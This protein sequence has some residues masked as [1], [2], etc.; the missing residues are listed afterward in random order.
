MSRVRNV[1]PVFIVL[2][3]P[4]PIYLA[5]LDATAGLMVDDAWY[6]MLAKALANGEGYRLINSPIADIL[7]MYPPGF[8]ALLSLGFH[9]YP[10]FP[11]NLWV[12]KSLSI[13]AMLGVGLLSYTY[14]HRDRQLPRHLAACA[15]VAITTTPALVFLAT[16]TVMSECVFTLA[17]LGAV[18]AA[19]R[20][21]Q[22]SAEGAWRLVVVAALLAAAAM[23]IR[24]AGVA[25]IAAIGIFFLKDLQWKRAL[26][27]AGVLVISL[28][29]WLVYARAHHPTPEQQESHRGSIVY[30]YTDQ[31]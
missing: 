3:L 12:L 10:T 22:P 21:A 14:F 24:S 2:L 8:P 13:G 1:V 17:Q 23:L 31:F 27:F 25:V 30:G 4:L 29:P 15:A 20:A 5:R 6:I 9:L 28:G 11:E 19:H 7:P 16:S 26:L 18:V